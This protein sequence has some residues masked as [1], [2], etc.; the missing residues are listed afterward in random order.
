MLKAASNANATAPPVS[1][2]KP[3]G[4][5]A[6]SL[7][8]IVGTQQ[9]GGGA[10]A[11]AVAEVEDE[12]AAGE[13]EDTALVLVQIL[14]L[15]FPLCE[16]VLDPPPPPAATPPRAIA[17]CSAEAARPSN[18]RGDGSV[19]GRVAELGVLPEEEEEEEEGA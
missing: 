18:S 2:A 8:A 17:N 11:A 14:A 12:A 3:S 9:W 10:V 16:G 15:L 7:R 19:G 13:E 6:K 5:D 4:A 1:A